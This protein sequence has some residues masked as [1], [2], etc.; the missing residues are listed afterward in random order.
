MTYPELIAALFP[1][2]APDDFKGH[3]LLLPV[4]TVQAMQDAQ[5]AV[6]SAKHKVHPVA[7]TDGRYLIGADILPELA[8]GGIFEPALPLFNMSALGGVDVVPWAD[9]VALLPVADDATLAQHGMAV[10]DPPQDGGQSV[11]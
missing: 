3:A 8:P 10:I 9:G 11:E 7:T 2:G 4:A 1:S 6:G 5:D